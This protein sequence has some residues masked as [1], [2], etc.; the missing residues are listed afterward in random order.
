MKELSD[1]RSFF[2]DSI[3]D[4]RDRTKTYDH[5]MKTQAQQFYEQNKA[6]AQ[7]QYGG[8]NASPPKGRRAKKK[9]A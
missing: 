7:E 5:Y 8:G 2:A 1:Q 6:I 9:S 4:I 3:V